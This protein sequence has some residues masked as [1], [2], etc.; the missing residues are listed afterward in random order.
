MGGGER[1]AIVR[2]E[3]DVSW[4]VERGRGRRRERERDNGI[5]H[6]GGHGEYKIKTCH[7]RSPPWGVLLMLLG[8]C[9]SYAQI[10]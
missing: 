4:R 6:Q 1:T 8:Q 7:G 3:S 9:G 10:S 2:G 5:Y